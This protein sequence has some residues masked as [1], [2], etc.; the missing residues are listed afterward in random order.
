MRAELVII[1]AL[2]A[3]CGGETYS[4]GAGRPVEAGAAPLD[5]GPTPDDASDAPDD[6]A[7]SAPLAFTEPAP[8][9]AL[10]DGSASDDDPALTADL[11]VLYFNSK[12]EGGKGREDIWHTTRDTVSEPFRAP[13]PVS[14]LNSDARETGIALS[15][16]GLTVWFS[17]DREGGAG[18]LDVYSATRRTRD[19]PFA[20][21]VS[22]A[23]LN[24]AQDD[25]VSFVDAARGTLYLARRE[26]EDDDYDLF[27][28]KR[29]RAD[30]AWEAAQPLSELNTDAAESDAFAAAEGTRLL[31]TRA[32]EL[33]LSERMSADAFGVAVP[34]TALNSD[35]DDRDAWA[36]EDLSLVVFSSKR[37]G[38]YLLY[39]ARRR[40]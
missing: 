40:D 13:R 26:S 37:S 8:I 2:A 31:F 35:E 21:I 6:D 3:A 30:A 36:T 18:G 39:E 29:A 24:S 17:S 20:G 7:G 15:A 11:R 38:S 28:A 10:D 19:E 32:G 33:M 34:L 9:A 27:V 4:L 22:V 1:A 5:A 14:E 23:A 25:L 12:R 16:D